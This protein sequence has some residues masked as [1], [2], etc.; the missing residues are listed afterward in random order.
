[1][2]AYISS[3]DVLAWYSALWAEAG[4]GVTRPT[5]MTLVS[6]MAAAVK[7]GHIDTS[8]CQVPGGQKH[9]PPAEPK[10]QV[11]TPEE[12]RTA[13]NAMPNDLRLA[14]HLAAW[15][16]AREGEIIGLQRRDLTLDDSPTLHIRR[17]IQY[18]TGEGPVTTGPKSTAGDRAITIPV[19]LIPLIRAHLETHTGGA[20]TAPVFHRPDLIDQPIHPNTLRSHWNRARAAAGIPWFRFHDLR[21]TGL[22]VFA[23]QGATLAEL[24]HR[25]GHSDVSVALRYQHATQ[26]RDRALA[27]SMDTSILT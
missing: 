2:L 25:G 22:T 20:P 26:A 1:M 12:V 10:R 7:A 9:H 4:P 8:P 11:A 17:Q 23:Q 5:Y 18:L 24:L 21:H 13:A 14:V 27:D 15:C 19:S 16:Q 6:L 3:G